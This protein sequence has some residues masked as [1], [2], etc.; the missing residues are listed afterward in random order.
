MQGDYEGDREITRAIYKLYTAKTSADMDNYMV[1][2][3]YVE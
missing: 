1:W 2:C 3:D